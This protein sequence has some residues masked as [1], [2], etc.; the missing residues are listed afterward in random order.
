[1]PSLNLH[2][3]KVSLIRLCPIKKDFYFLKAANLLITKSAA[4]PAR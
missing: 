1:M 4:L 3:R 2:L